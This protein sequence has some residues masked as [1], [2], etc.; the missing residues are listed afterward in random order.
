VVTTRIDLT[1]EQLKAILDARDEDMAAAVA[2]SNEHPIR[3]FV[4]DDYAV[5]AEVS[6]IVA[7]NCT[8]ALIHSYQVFVV[9]VESGVSYL[10][11]I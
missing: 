7:Q 8:A 2:L 11:V 4:L 5:R 9:P 3:P 1:S 10:E 6:K